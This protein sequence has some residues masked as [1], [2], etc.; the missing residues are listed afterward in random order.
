MRFESG[1]CRHCQYR[2]G[3]GGGSPAGCQTQGAA[4]GSGIVI[5]RY[6][7]SPAVTGGTIT[8]SGGYT[9]HTFTGN[10]TFEASSTLPIDFISLKAE[11]KSNKV[12]VSWKVSAESNIVN[13]EVERS[14]DG[15]QFTSIGNVAA[16]GSSQYNFTD[17]RPVSA[18]SYYRI[19]SAAITGG[20]KYSTIIKLQFGNSSPVVSIYPNPVR[21]Q[22]GISLT[23]AGGHLY[24]VRILNLYGTEV[25][26]RS[27]VAF[28]TTTLNL[29]VSILAAGSCMVEITSSNSEKTVNKFIKNYYT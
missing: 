13:Y 21:D 6:L 16:S 2:R 3:G 10:G 9:I 19:K 22:L 4:G 20:V 23:N 24:E 8:Q 5:I 14:A 7:G 12:A 27:R 15:R 11:V 1:C 28:N 29:D 26:R 17:S 25:I 18:T